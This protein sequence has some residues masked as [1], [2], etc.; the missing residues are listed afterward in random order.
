MSN[1]KVQ[2]KHLNEELQRRQT[3]EVDQQIE[4]DENGAMK[5]LEEAKELIRSLNSQNSELRSKLEVLASATRE[6][7]ESRSNSSARKAS[8]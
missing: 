4:N 1:M 7:S 3:P 8:D 5:E 2:I 6:C